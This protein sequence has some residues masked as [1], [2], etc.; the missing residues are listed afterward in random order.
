[1]FHI[2]Q[3]TDLNDLFD[4]SMG[5]LMD[6][7]STHDRKQTPRILSYSNL[8]MSSSLEWNFDLSTV[9]FTKTRW[10]RY[11]HQYFDLESLKGWLNSLPEIS[12][13]GENLFRSKDAIRRPRE[14]KHGSCWLGLSFRMDPPTLILYSRVAE[15]PTRAALELTMVHKVGQEISSRLKIPLNTIHLVWFISSGF[16]SCLHLLP[17]L[18]SRGLLDEAYHRDDTVG[19]FIRHQVDHI[20]KGNVVY[21][22][23][24]RMGKRVEQMKAGT[25]IPVPVESISIWV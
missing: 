2:Y 25:V 11:V 6:E 13:R 14:H 23:T 20:K 9:G 15:F 17:Y 5:L 4:K 21:G 7:P 8:L 16:L 1:M 10:P 19:E 24:K 3:S 22:P 12:R 18:Q